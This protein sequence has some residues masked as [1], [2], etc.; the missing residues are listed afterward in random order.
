MGSVRGDSLSHASHF[1]YAKDTSQDTQRECV[2]WEFYVDSSSPQGKKR[3]SRKEES[4]IL[5]PKIKLAVIE[6]PD[7]DL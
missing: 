2:L 6:I 7:V 4:R 3:S 1:H 5:S